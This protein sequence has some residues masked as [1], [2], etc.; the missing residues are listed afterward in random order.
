[1]AEPLPET[2]RFLL[3]PH[4]RASITFTGGPVTPSDLRMLQRYL[5]L[6]EEALADEPEEVPHA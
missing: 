4:V 3:A 1:M 2:V 5:V 6:A